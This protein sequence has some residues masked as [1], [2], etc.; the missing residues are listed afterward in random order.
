MKKFAGILLLLLSLPMVA[1]F[2]QEQGEQED[3]LPSLLKERRS[4]KVMFNRE[5]AVREINRERLNHSNAIFTKWGG[6]PCPTFAC[7]DLGGK[8]WTNEKIRGKVTLINFWHSESAPCVREIPWFN[9]LMRKYPQAN[10]LACTFNTSEQI[11]EIV[12]GTPFLYSQLADATA[13]W[14]LFGVTL[15]PAMI[16]LDEEGNVVTVVTGVSDALKRTVEAR[17]KE[18]HKE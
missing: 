4:G 8:E 5:Q 9:K 2:A 3:K 1:V 14:K 7:K 17:L 11:K 16:L 12:T 13:L 10:F 15:S 18:L 6:K